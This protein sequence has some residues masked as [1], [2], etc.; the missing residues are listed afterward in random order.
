MSKR[1]VVITGLG[2]VSPVGIGAQEA[3]ANVLAGKSGVGPITKFDAS[4]LPTRI[5]AEVKG[6]N[7][8]D[9]MHPKETR[10]SDLFV[11]YGIAA[12]KMALDDAGLVIDEANGENPATMDESQLASLVWLPCTRDT[13]HGD[14]ASLVTGPGLEP[15]GGVPSAPPGI[16]RHWTFAWNSTEDVGQTRGAFLVRATPF[17][18]QRDHGSTVY[19]RIVIRR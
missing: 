17:D 13:T 12:T 9:W 19:S 10:R 11:H 7:S 18:A 16:G 1:R 5:A 3:W 2:V 8:A 15:T 14:D 4:A 6:F